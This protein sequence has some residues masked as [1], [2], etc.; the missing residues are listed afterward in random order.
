MAATA[1]ASRPYWAGRFVLDRYVD[2]LGIDAFFNGLAEWT[3]KTASS[4]RRLQNGFVRSY[5]LFVLIGGV[6]MLGYLLLK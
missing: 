4:L 6:A 1:T 5:A 2:Q 3:R